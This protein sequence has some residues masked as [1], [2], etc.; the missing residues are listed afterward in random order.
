MIVPTLLVD[1]FQRCCQDTAVSQ[2]VMVKRNEDDRTVMIFAEEH[3]W[4]KRQ[5]REVLGIDDFTDADVE[6]VL[7]GD[8]SKEAD[9]FN[10]ELTL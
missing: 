8:P 6:A 1:T 9:A 5:D 3:Q 10:H 2:P 7:R 4:L